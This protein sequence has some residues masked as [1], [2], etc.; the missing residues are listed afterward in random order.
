MSVGRIEVD[1]AALARWATNHDAAAQD[2]EGARADG[3]KIVE[4][5]DSWGA[6]F[7]EARRA[8]QEVI[9]ARE[10]ALAAQAER[11]RNM[12]DQLRVGGAAFAAMNEDNAADLGEIAT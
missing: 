4:A 8:A 5:T 2:L 10:R 1:P 12:A 11:H 7:H 6:M 3:A 9:E